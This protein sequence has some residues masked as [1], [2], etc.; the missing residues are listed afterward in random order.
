MNN[1]IATP[2]TLSLDPDTFALPVTELGFLK[3]QASQFSRNDSCMYAVIKSY[4]DGILTVSSHFR[5]AQ[6]LHTIRIEKDSLKFSCSCSAAQ[7]CVHSKALLTHLVQ[8]K[9][10]NYFKQFTSFP[11]NDPKKYIPYVDISYNQS[12]L[13]IK[14][15]KEF[16]AI[17]N[18]SG[19]ITQARPYLW[20]AHIPVVVAPQQ[21][22]GYTI[23]VLDRNCGL[24]FL[25][26][27]Q[28]T[29]N[30][31]KT[32]VKSFTRFLNLAE[33]QLGFSADQRL[34]NSYCID[35]NK[36][37]NLETNPAAPI[38]GTDF[39][40]LQ[41]KNRQLAF[42]YWKE[43]LP[44][45]K[46]QNHLFHYLFCKKIAYQAKPQKQQMYPITLAAQQASFGLTLKEEEEGHLSLTC[47]AYLGNKQ[48]AI[49]DLYPYYCPFF[50]S[51][52][53]DP[54]AWYL[55]ANL[56]EAAIVNALKKSGFLL[57]ILKEDL[58]QFNTEVLNEWAAAF[59]VTFQLSEGS[60]TISLI[61]V[62]KEIRVTEKEDA[63][64]FTPVVDYKNGSTVDIFSNGTQMLG[65]SG[66]GYQVLQRDKAAEEDFKNTFL[67]LHPS[68][69]AQAE[70]RVFFLPKALFA[71]PFWL[72]GLLQ[73][74]DKAGITVSGL[75]SLTDLELDYTP[76][77]VDLVVNAD[78]DWFDITVSIDYGEQS[79]N[80]EEIGKALKNS[81]QGFRLQNGK[82]AF[83]PDR[84]IKDLAPAFSHGQRTS[85]GLKVA[86]RHYSLIDKLVK[87]RQLPEVPGLKLALAQRQKAFESREEIE[88]VVAPQNIKAVLRPYQVAGFSWM[89]NLHAQQWGGLL[90]DDMGLGKTLQVLALLQHLKNNKLCTLPH[91]LVAPTSLLFN[92][93]AEAAR[94]CPDLRVTTY[95]GLARDRDIR[96]LMNYDLVLTSYG[97]VLVDLEFLQ[98]VPFEYLVL[99]EAQAIKNPLSQRFKAMTL[100]NAKSRLALT[101]TPVE[102][103]TTDLYAL[104]SFINPGFFGTPKLLNARAAA[105]NGL[106]S[107]ADE[108]LLQMIQ[109]FVLRRTKDRVA[110]DLPAKT[111]MIIWCEME[112]AQRRVYDAYRKQFKE[113]LMERF[114]SEGLERSKLYVLDGLMKLRQICNSPSLVKNAAA[115]T[116][117]N[118]KIEELMLHIT[119]KTGTHKVLVFSQFT[120]MLGLIRERLTAEG[121]GFAYLDGATRID[122]RKEAVDR[123]QQGAETRVFLISLKAGGTGLNLTAADYV[124]LVD[125]WWNPAAES[126]AIDRS[127][128]IGQEKHVMAY[129]MICKDTLEEKIL[130]IQQKKK[131]LAGDLLDT[132]EGVL[133]SMS[134]EDILKL[135]G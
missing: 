11:F 4:V 6:Y 9:G 52:E 115:Y 96:R 49:K 65:L 32:D 97:T 126:Q 94:F 95:H 24:P 99:D 79:L 107:K 42:N 61:P 16:G 117:S 36:L 46:C 123:F 111:E 118:C 17:Y 41:E 18:R 93:K 22:T 56:K 31:A 68:F 127:H 121:I 66:T 88:M 57:T 76:P 47:M 1:V 67:G 125:P 120:G 25:I 59:P 69:A 8:H 64:Y 34:L 134:K 39:A 33:P 10:L 110:T 71:D 119:E 27:Y 21:V 101:G 83:L 58:K 38:P 77:K 113:N 73:Q 15:K 98:Q 102:N 84:L 91:L 80:V 53:D 44:V 103:C 106:N 12:E 26:P 50:F 129:R 7:L 30:E 124:Y 48:I 45:L 116:G 132:K 5:G 13:I 63:V 3:T 14:S 109:P 20:A 92:W 54:D 86:G 130:A 90:A 128:R 87:G 29:L 51:L 85:R 74:L 114:D 19:N 70:H 105:N 81:D 133:K 135:F 35:F 60:T 43:L 89:C 72:N 62:R 37:V 40:L 122:H 75:E 131:K 112:P 78:K 28:G 108:E 104:L 55:F 100:I 2:F 82:I 23:G